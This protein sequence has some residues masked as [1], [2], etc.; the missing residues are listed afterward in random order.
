MYPWKKACIIGIC[1]MLPLL[2][3]GF[4]WTSWFDDSFNPENT[5]P[6]PSYSNTND[7]A[8]FPDN[9]THALKADVFYIHPTTFIS[10]LAW[11]ANVR[12]NKVNKET[13]STYL[14]WQTLPFSD[15]A[16][17]YAPYYRQA[18]LYAFVPES[19]NGPKEKDSQQALDVAYA[20]IER[21]FDYYM[22]RYNHGRPLF[23][24]SHSQGSYLAVRL[25]QN[26][27]QSYHLNKVLVA[28]Y[29]VGEH[30]G[31]K[32]FSH[33][34]VCA[35]PTQTRCFVTWASVLQGK[36]PLLVTG[37][38]L[39]KPVCVNPLT[40]SLVKPTAS[41][42]ENLGGVPRNL[43]RVDPEIVDARCAQ[44]ILWISSPGK[45]DYPSYHGDY[46]ESDFNLFFMNIQKNAQA[47][48]NVFT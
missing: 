21:A 33:L 26:K 31:T 42:R 18:T 41:A 24:V 8:T 36:K 38:A 10:E 25:L 14:K 44:G 47:R 5:P 17:I 13:K 27:Y 28:A 12:D 7:W 40:F 23:I 11:N 16:R 39:G 4:S 9:N 6:A 48:L 19:E 46:H 15:I 2:L 45:L 1:T 30:I 3:M 29:L 43:N 34:P 20:D 37:T 35:T 22:K 32:T